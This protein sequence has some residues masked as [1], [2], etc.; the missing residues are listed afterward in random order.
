MTYQEHL[1]K[2]EKKH[3]EYKDIFFA[4]NDE[5]F[6]EGMKSLGLKP[7]DY[8]KI[9]RIDGGGFILKATR[10]KF[11]ECFLSSNDELQSLLQDDAFLLD[12]LKYELCNH[13]YCITYNYTDALETLN[14]TFEDLSNRK[15]GLKILKQATSYALEAC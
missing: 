14:L 1:K 4:F 11:H 6:N 3:R 5:Q 7:D 8:D 13:E 9:L 10:D 12:A 2:Q 15:N